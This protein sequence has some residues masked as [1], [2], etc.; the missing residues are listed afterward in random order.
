MPEP[1]PLLTIA[2]P[3]YNRSVYL[4]EFLEI[5]LPQMEPVADIEL[6]ICNNAAT[7]DTNEV[8]RSMVRADDPRY[9]LI[10]NETNIGSDA[11]FVKCFR[12]ARGKYLW[13]CGDDDILRPGSIDCL[14]PHL[15]SG[16]YDLIYIEPEGFFRDWRK[17]HQPDPLQRSHSVTTSA[18]DMAL[19]LGTMV[20]FITATVI[21]RDR[22]LAVIEEQP[23]A[24][25][26]TSLVHLSWLFPLLDKHRQSLCLWQR[27]VAGRS[28]NSSF[29]VAE[30]FGRRFGS[31][32]RRLFLRR[33]RLAKTFINL[34][35]R[36][37]FPNMLL[38]MR[39]HQ[40]RN[41]NYGLEKTASVMHELFHGNFRYWVFVKPVLMLPLPMARRWVRANVLVNKVIGVMLR[42]KKIAE[43]IT[44]RLQHPSGDLLQS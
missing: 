13:L 19:T 41:N 22:A 38:E 7:D 8:V 31:I 44:R 33:P 2:V 30:I 18:R 43:K 23:E 42:P 29:D 24:L 14:M 20:A 25:I 39:E 10:V 32:A 17:E 37:W 5:L 16:E 27:W 36:Q 34:N 15:R 12:E 21:N 40:G 3:T 26:G 9:R 4:Q 11:N 35:L 28:M 6:L 1:Q